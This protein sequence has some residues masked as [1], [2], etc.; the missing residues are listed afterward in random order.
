MSVLVIVELQVK[1]ECFSDLIDYLE[2]ILPDTRVYEGC[3]ELVVYS[4]TKEKKSIVIV[5]QWESQ[6]HYENYHA[7]RTE[8][9]VLDNIRAMLAAKASIQF[10][11]KID[12]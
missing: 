3:H 2:Y 8:T 5:E 1:S 11:D 4:N 6:K 10:Y 12:V 7:W 9:G